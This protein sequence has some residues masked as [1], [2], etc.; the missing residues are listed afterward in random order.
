MPQISDYL[1]RKASIR[2]VPLGG[3]FEL[4]PVCNFACKM[5]YV[6]KTPSQIAAEGK[7]LRDWTEWLALAEACR[8]EGMLFLLLTGGEPFLYPHFR[9]LYER[10]HAMGL[11]LAI[12]SNGTLIDEETLAWLKRAAPSRVNITLYGASPETYRRICGHA[13]GYTRAMNAIRMLHAAGIPVVIN[14][15][16]IPENEGDLEEIF[17]FG[18]GLGLNVRMATYMFP[19]IRR[20][21][22]ESDSRFSP[23]QAA[24]VYL[25]KL[26]C[27]LTP[28]GY[29]A[30]L[31]KQLAESGGEAP[32]DAEDW[33][34]HQGEGELM[35]CRAGRSSFW[36]SWDGTMTACGLTPFPV[37]VKPFERDFHDCWMELT[38][39]VRST[40]ALRECAGCPRRTACN[41]CVAMLYAETG[42]VN[43][44]AP[45]LCEMSQ[46]IV[47]KMKLEYKGG[48][49]NE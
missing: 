29:Q 10:L 18:R 19:P 25:R 21:R 31:G 40:M 39:Q 11:V 14:A 30:E 23:E 44:K 4:S 16:M 7:R 5:C 42:D 9:E 46:K 34:S 1:Y 37:Q 43:Y 22:E 48:T 12:N 3:S 33:G 45:Y 36:V 24:G 32:G 38:N 47:E 49:S 35:R 20:G 27:L 8:R 26:R 28:E 17:A 13:D 15:S 6:R 41:P 2:K